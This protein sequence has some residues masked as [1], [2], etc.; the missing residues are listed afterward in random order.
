MK[1]KEGLKKAILQTLEL[2]KPC[3]LDADA[4]SVFEG[5]EGTLLKSL[6]LGC[7]LT[8]HEG[9]FRRIFPLLT[10]SKLEQVEKAAKKAGCTVLLK[11]PDT[12]IAAPERK[13]VINSLSV[14]A[15]ATAGS[16]DVLAGVI[17]GY[18]AQGVP[19]FDAAC[20][21]AWVH[22]RAGLRHGPGLVAT[23]LPG[24]IPEVLKE[25]LQ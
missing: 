14:P 15:L 23:D 4:L 17:T 11:G 8:P 19:G 2:Q 9:E 10:G 22:A 16:G 1:D 3:V 21:G 13:S 7:V 25:L 20:I 6:H 18:M 24:L 12:V 5:E